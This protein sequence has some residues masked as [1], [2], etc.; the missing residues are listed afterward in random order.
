MYKRQVLGFVALAWGASRL[1]DSLDNAIARIFEGSA[2][3][4]PVERGI[5]GVLIVLI[6]VGLGMAGFVAV[7]LLSWL[8]AATPAE[9]SPLASFAASLAESILLNVFFFCAIAALIYRYVPTRRPAWRILIRPA[10]AVGLAGAAL[11]QFF[12]VLAPRL[13]GSLQ[14]YGAFVAILA[15]MVWLSFICQ[16]VLIGAAWVQTRSATAS[17]TAGEAPP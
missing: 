14:V 6:A 5:R 10:I 2:R 9:I 16:G 17:T 8:A 11:T 4:D 3:R 13:V 12:A 7:S 15:T 1:Y